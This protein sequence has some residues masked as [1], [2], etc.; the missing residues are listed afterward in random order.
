VE[1]LLEGESV[2]GQVRAEQL[3]VGA[4]VCRDIPHS[5]TLD[6]AAAATGHLFA[7]TA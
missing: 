5:R 4:V 6:S 7:A 3:F 2:P 1:Q